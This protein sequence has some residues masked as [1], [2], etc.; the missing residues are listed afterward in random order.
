VL[1]AVPSRGNLSE[2]ATSAI[3]GYEIEVAPVSIGHR[4]A[5]MHALTVGQAAQEYEIRGKAAK[6]IKNLYM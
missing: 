3:G 2:E 4:A 6:E 5:Y 1:N